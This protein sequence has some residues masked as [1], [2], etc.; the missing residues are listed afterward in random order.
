MAFPKGF[1][2]VTLLGFLGKD[3]VFKNN[4]ALLS[5]ATEYSVKKDDGS[6]EIATE[7]TRVVCFSKLA[8]IARDYLRKGSQVLIVGR[9]QTQ[10]Y[11]DQQGQ[12]RYITEVIA[13]ELK[14]VGG[15]SLDNGHGQ[16]DSG[17]GEYRQEYKQQP[18]P[19]PMAPPQYAPPPPGVPMGTPMPQYTQATGVPP[20]PPPNTSPKQFDDD[21]PF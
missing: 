16:Y 21:I 5:V 7:W 1:N 15:K 3:P 11:Q 4:R 6:W 13:N 2:Q 19:P 14:L 9:L 18:S 20:P 8:E 10:K 17:G 12:D